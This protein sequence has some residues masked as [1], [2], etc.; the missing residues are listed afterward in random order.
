MKIAA[1]TSSRR[2]SLKPATPPPVGQAITAAA[3]LAGPSCVSVTGVVLCAGKCGGGV[4]AVAGVRGGSAPSVFWTAAIAASALT[5]PN[6]ITSIG[7]VLSNGSHKARNAAGVV[8]SI[9]LRLGVPQRGSPS[10]SSRSR[11]RDSTP[12]GEAFDPA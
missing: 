2:A 7:P 12:V 5:S 3:W 11:S 1:S 9:A 8:A 4:S 10:R 6:T